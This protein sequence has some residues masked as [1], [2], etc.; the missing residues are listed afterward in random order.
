MALC[1]VKRHFSVKLNEQRRRGRQTKAD[2]DHK[3]QTVP[4]ASMNITWWILLCF[5]FCKLRIDHSWKNSIPKSGKRKPIVRI[6]V[7]CISS[8]CL[9][10]QTDISSAVVEQHQTPDLHSW[11]MHPDLWRNERPPFTRLHHGKWDPTAGKWAHQVGYSRRSTDTFIICCQPVRK[12][13]HG[14]CCRGR[15]GDLDAGE[16]C[17]N[18]LNWTEAPLNRYIYWK[19][20]FIFFKQKQNKTSKQDFFVSCMRH[21]TSFCCIFK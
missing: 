2:R 20:G 4:C 12:G 15:G 6:S 11:V 8:E 21:S 9:V 18:C 14:N 1:A 16:C 10:P 5:L 17:V 7:L 19:K 3:G 13:R